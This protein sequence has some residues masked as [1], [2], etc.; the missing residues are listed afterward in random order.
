[1]QLKISKSSSNGMTCLL[2]VGVDR[3]SAFNW[4]A[5]GLPRG[6]YNEPTRFCCLI[7]ASVY[8]PLPTERRICTA[9]NF[10]LQHEDQSMDEWTRNQSAF[11]PQWKFSFSR[12]L[13]LMVW[14]S[15][16]FTDENFIAE[17]GEKS[18]SYNIKRSQSI[19]HF[20]MQ[21]VLQGHL[22]PNASILARDQ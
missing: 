8:K 3:R 16:F 21:Y 20:D 2:L 11:G 1:M 4:K 10:E 12:K 17:H 18:Q 14:M 5:W 19:S 15:R 9:W 13:A 7:L 22:T 6:V